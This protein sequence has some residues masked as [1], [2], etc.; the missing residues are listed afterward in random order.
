MGSPSLSIFKHQLRHSPEQPEQKLKKPKIIT[1]F[2]MTGDIT[3]N[4]DSHNC[5]RTVGSGDL[6]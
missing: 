1:D 5:V 6:K 3:Q 4:F 2:T